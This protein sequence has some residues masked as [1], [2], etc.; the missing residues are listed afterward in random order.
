MNIGTRRKENNVYP[1]IFLNQD[2]MFSSLKLFIHICF[3]LFFILVGCGRDEKRFETYIKGSGDYIH[4][5]TAGS[6]S[7]KTKFL[8]YYEEPHKAW[9]LFGNEEMNE[10]ILYELPSGNIEKRLKLDFR[11]P[12]RIGVY[13]G[14]FIHNLDSIFVISG[15][16]YKDFFLIDT[17]GTV[18]R[19]FSVDPLDIGEFHNALAPLYSHYSMEALFRN[20]LLNLN[21][22][23]LT[24]ISNADL[25]TQSI[26]VLYDIGKGELVDRFKYPEFDDTHKASLEYYCRTHNGGD[27]VYS[28]RRLD[29]LYILKENGDYEIISCPS[30]FQGQDLD[31]Y[32]NPTDPIEIQKER[33]IENPCYGSIMFDKYRRL[34]YRIYIP[35]YKLKNGESADQYIGY[36]PLFSI[37]VLD[38]NLTLIGE[39]LMPMNKYDPQMAFITRDGLFLA[40]HPNHPKYDPDSLAFE[41]MVITEN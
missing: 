21:T 10:A 15:T 1:N 9:L 28:F 11:G 18:K 12:N 8:Q 35:G 6:I 32:N 41:K 23:V 20:G 19:Q 36:P 31:W 24:A 16:Y 29:D 34:Y 33:S 13:K 26:C 27:L 40:L 17:T 2:Q 25:H 22:Y 4:L 39:T 5:N 7:P 14:A 37:M 3:L 38:E 30:Q